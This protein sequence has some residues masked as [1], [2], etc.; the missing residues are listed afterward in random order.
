MYGTLPSD[1][2]PP[3]NGFIWKWHT[4]E[5]NPVTFFWLCIKNKPAWDS[6]TNSSAK[7]RTG[8]PCQHLLVAH[9]VPPTQT[10]VWRAAAGPCAQRPPH[11]SPPVRPCWQPPKE[12]RVMDPCGAESPSLSESWA[13]APWL[14]ASFAP[15][16][17]HEGLMYSGTAWIET[18]EKEPT[19]LS[20][21][22]Q[23]KL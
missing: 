12:A 5:G 10:A 20:F 4:A 7:A 21:G 6:S 8:E 17:T 19:L 16:P 14:L 1:Q 2:F 13:S 11:L 15:H 3:H 22:I 9:C 18:G 23:E